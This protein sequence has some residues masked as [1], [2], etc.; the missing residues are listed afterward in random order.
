MPSP[1]S[2]PTRHRTHIVSEAVVSAYIHEIAQSSRAPSPSRSRSRERGEVHTDL[3]DSV[4]AWL[5]SPPRARPAGRVRGG[6]VE[7]RRGRGLELAA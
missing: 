6:A 2:N 7:R 1:S 3:V 4:G 5:S